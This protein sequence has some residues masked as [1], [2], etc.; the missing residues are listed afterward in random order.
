MQRWMQSD[1]M[2]TLIYDLSFS[3]DLPFKPIDKYLLFASKSQHVIAWLFTLFLK[4][5]MNILI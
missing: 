3:S 4:N 2:N 1:F 5:E